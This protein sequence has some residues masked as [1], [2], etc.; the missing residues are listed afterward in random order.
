MKNVFV[1]IYKYISK[2]LYVVN[3]KCVWIHQFL[4]C[5]IFDN[6]THR[7]TMWIYQRRFEKHHD[8]NIKPGLLTNGCLWVMWSD[9]PPSLT[10][11]LI[12]ISPFSLKAVLMLMYNAILLRSSTHLHKHSHPCPHLTPTRSIQ[13]VALY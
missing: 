10:P 2:S 13:K 9:M 3:V 4:F 6:Q 5:I 12:A 11:Q 8:G 7:L 1:S